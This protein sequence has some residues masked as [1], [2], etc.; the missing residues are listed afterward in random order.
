MGTGEKRKMAKRNFE[1]IPISEPVAT[2]ST[3]PKRG[4]PTIPDDLLSATRNDWVG[5]LED[6]WP[7]IGPRMR[8]IRAKRKATI[9]D[10]RK[11]FELVAR[12]I[13]R[14]DLAVSFYNGSVEPATPTEIL[15][16]RKRTEKLDT[17]RRH[18][19]AKSGELERKYHDAKV[20]LE[21]CSA[22][23]RSKIQTVATKR[24]QDLTKVKNDLNKFHAQCTA[25]E[26]KL[27]DQEAY[28]NQSELLEFLQSCRYAINPQNVANALAGLPGMKWRQ[29]YT[30]CSHMPY[31]AG[32]RPSHLVLEVLLKIWDKRPRELEGPPI[33]FFR[34]K[35]VARKRSDSTRQFMRQHWSDLKLAIDES[36]KSEQFPADIP[37]VI[38]SIFMRNVNRPKNAEEKILAEA[39]SLESLDT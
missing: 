10:V 24:R 22:A 29:S 37:Y 26:K 38:G 11:L 17:Q 15:R 6:F 36:W 16:N 2:V 21:Q 8:Q 12:N 27:L 1:E 7:E 19:E 23:N 20:A 5:V 13:P 14:F 35:L 33:D 3:K 32:D 28:V 25:L 18:T 4:R 34:S 31:V 9:E 30:C 39:E